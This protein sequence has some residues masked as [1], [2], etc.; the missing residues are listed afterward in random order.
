MPVD[1]LAVILLSLVVWIVYVCDR[2]LDSRRLDSHSQATV[3][4]EFYARHRRIWLG[5]LGMAIVVVGVL[6]TLAQ[7]ALLGFGGTMAALTGGYLVGVHR[8]WARFS[9]EM[10]CGVVFALGSALSL[11]TQ[12]IPGD[13]L[14][15]IFAVTAFAVLCASNCFA[16]A[17]AECA[18]DANHDPMAFTQ[19]YPH[20]HLPL[21]QLQWFLA[22]ASLVLALMFRQPLFLLIAAS[23]IALSLLTASSIARERHRVWADVC[24]LSPLVWI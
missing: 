6:T 11:I 9:K 7:P 20:L 13:L 1:T 2:L 18:V 10:A 4:H 8:R 15:F 12:G 3:R 22:L 23:H 21:R 19:R 5:M 16:I 14:A 17:Q 24:L